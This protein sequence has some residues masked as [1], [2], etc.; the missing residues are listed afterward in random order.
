MKFTCRADVFFEV[1][2][3]SEDE[4]F[5]KGWDFLAENT[6]ENISLDGAEMEVEPMKEG[7]YKN[8]NRI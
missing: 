4:A 7:R 1:E 2:A 8:E 5:G 3:D 6:T